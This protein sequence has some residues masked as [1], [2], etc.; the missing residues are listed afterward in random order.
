[1]AT[2]LPLVLFTSGLS[3]MGAPLSGCGV[4]GFTDGAITSGFGVSAA[5]VLGL[6]MEMT[7]HVQPKEISRK[8]VGIARTAQPIEAALRFRDFNSTELVLFTFVEPVIENYVRK[9]FRRPKWYGQRF[10]MHRH[11][12]H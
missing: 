2:Y 12:E 9:P 11:M 1:M 3:V 6:V 10:Q 7:F 8:E 5:R 4:A